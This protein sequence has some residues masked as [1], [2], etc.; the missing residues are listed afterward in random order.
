MPKIDLVRARS[1][2]DRR[3]NLQEG[4][5]KAVDCMLSNGYN[6]HHSSEQ[7]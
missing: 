1:F 4:L 3:L 6:A 2:A 5:L 7:L